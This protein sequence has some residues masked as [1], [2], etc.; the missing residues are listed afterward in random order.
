MLSGF[1][2]LGRVLRQGYSDCLEMFVSDFVALN[3]IAQ[4]GANSQ[5]S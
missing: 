1:A 2:L 4:D 5:N 3:K